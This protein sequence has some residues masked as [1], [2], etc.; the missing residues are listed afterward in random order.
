MVKLPEN[1]LNSVTFRINEA[2]GNAL[3]ENEVRKYLG[4]SSVGYPCMRKV[5]FSYNGYETSNV[6]DKGKM[7]RIF[8]MG[9]TVE[10]ML[11]K[12]LRMAGFEITDEQLEFSDFDDRFKGHCDGIIK[13]VTKK[14]HI[15]EIKSASMYNFEKMKKESV[16]S[17]NPAYGAQI[18]LYMGYAQLERGIFVVMCKN[19]QEIYTERVYFDQQEFE[20]LRAKALMILESEKAPE[21]DD[22]NCYF[23]DFRG[24]TCE[25]ADIICHKCVHKLEFSNYPIKALFDKYNLT[26]CLI[27]DDCFC[28]V[29]ETPA[30]NEC[31][32]YGE[33]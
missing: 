9:H 26:T 32:S 33:A 14:D 12:Y 23:C 20:A 21:K 10:E 1:F 18:Q 24:R 8:D 31:A 29:G 17:F 19:S 11:K 15:L 30:E 2:C 7:Y 27:E 6:S 13:G 28:G 16:A 25:K 4:M 22:T 5:W 3:D